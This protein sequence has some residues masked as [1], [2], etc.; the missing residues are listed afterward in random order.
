MTIAHTILDSRGHA[1]AVN[2]PVAPKRHQRSRRKGAKTPAGVIYVGRPTPFGNPFS[3]KRFGHAR[4]CAL[5][6]LWLDHRLGA[7][8]LE[9]RGFCPAEIEGLTRFRAA[10]DRHLPR[11]FGKDLQCWCP[12]TTRYCHAEHLLHYAAS[13]AALREFH[14]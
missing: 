9:R 12:L 1:P 13:A 10:L 2:A 4:A 11:L 7:R 6:S 14:P 3:T 5:Y 8:A